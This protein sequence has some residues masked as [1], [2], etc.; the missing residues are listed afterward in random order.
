[1]G[2]ISERIGRLGNGI[3]GKILEKNKMKRTGWKLELNN[4]KW[5]FHCFSVW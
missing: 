1:M 5:I 3:M 4:G 2:K